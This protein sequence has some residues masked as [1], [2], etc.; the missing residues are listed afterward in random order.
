MCHLN[1]NSGRMVGLY[2]KMVNSKTVELIEE[3]LVG[4]IKDSENLIVTLPNMSISVISKVGGSDLLASFYSKAILI[5]STRAR[6][7][8]SYESAYFCSFTSSLTEWS[9]VREY[10]EFT[11]S[12]I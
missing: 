2:A 1:D 9:T 3:I 12:T 8:S 6:I 10:V 4:T 5:G 7:S 11:Y